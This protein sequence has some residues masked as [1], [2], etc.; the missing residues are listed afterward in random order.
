MAATRIKSIKR[1]SQ[2]ASFVRG[3]SSTAAQ[4][5]SFADSILQLSST[6][7]VF[8]VCLFSFLAYA[9]SLGGEFVFDD[10]EQIVENQNIRSW[11]NIATAFTTSVWAFRDKHEALNVPPPLPYYRPLFTVM[12]T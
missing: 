5:N 1:K 12:L 8:L 11:G 2:A 6:R 3:D 7:I 9:N 4:S 10:T